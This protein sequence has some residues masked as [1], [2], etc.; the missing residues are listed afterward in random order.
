MAGFQMAMI[1]RVT[2]TK[3]REGIMAGGRSKEA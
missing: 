3:L 1:G 2:Y